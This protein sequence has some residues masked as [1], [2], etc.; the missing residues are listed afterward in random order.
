M[1]AFVSVRIV[2]C[3]LCGS[4]LYRATG[5][6]G[7]I[8]TAYRSRQGFDFTWKHAPRGLGGYFEAT[9]FKSDVC[10]NCGEILGT[11]FEPAIRF[12]KEREVGR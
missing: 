9:R 12:I 5:I 2:C 6:A 1:A 8:Q 4:A 11:L 10:N 3:P 7:P